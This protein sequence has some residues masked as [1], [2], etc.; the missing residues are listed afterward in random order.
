MPD[1]RYCDETFADEEGL[2]GHL[3]ETH[4][5]ELSRIDRRRVESFEAD[6]GRPRAVVY[7]GIAVVV[8]VL[9]VAVYLTVLQGGGDPV[10]G[11]EPT[12]LESEPLP[13]RGDPALLSDVEQFPSEGR[14]HV[15]QGS[16]VDYGT[17]PPTSGTHYPDWTDP[18][19]YTERQP[20]GNLVHSLEHG[21]VV[22]YYDPA[23]LTP[24]A[25]AS[26]RAWAR[27]H[28][29]RFNAVIVAPNPNDDPES[30]YVLTAWTV[31]L[32]S[33]EYD[34]EQVRAFL[35]EYKGR[36]PEHPVR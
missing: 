8:V 29:E 19:F 5:E 12:G 23:A 27:N 25:E 30:A 18:G 17:N 32:R 28:Q 20:A 3:G 7:G 4:R 14:G 11:A 1:C 36:G 31:M 22:I 10:P 16:Q 26:L 34:A 21:Y 9:A 6:D 2:L 15:D 24:E 35:A 33:D 13:E